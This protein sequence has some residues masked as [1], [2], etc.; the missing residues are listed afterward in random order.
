[1]IGL[2]QCHGCDY[3]VKVCDLLK[4]KKEHYKH[5]SQTDYFHSCVALVNSIIRGRVNNNSELLI[6]NG[7]YCHVSTQFISGLD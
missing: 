2:S 3:I 6:W 5:F 7:H 4:N 1:M